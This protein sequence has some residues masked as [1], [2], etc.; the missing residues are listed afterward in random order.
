[1]LQTISAPQQERLTIRVPPFRDRTNIDTSEAS[2]TDWETQEKP[3]GN[4][5]QSE[6]DSDETGDILGHLDSWLDHDKDDS[7]S[8]DAPDWTFEENE[9]RSKDPAYVFCPAP[10]RHQILRL[11]AT[12]F[13]MHPAFP[14]ESKG[15]MTAS[16]RH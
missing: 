4:E 10:H 3:D 11:F 12:H 7:D 2:F 1:M 5:V 8:E 6:P 14:E 15:F 9:V 13:C 16:D